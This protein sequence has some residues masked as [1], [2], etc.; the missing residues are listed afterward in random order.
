MSS[1]LLFDL[2]ARNILIGM[3]CNLYLI[4]LRFSHPSDKSVQSIATSG[5]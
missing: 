5:S 3:L 4:S 2:V 1:V